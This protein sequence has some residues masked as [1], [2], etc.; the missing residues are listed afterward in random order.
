MA[1]LNEKNRY[2]MFKRANQ[3]K[4]KSYLNENQFKMQKMATA[5]FR[6]LVIKLSAQN[7]TVIRFEQWKTF[8][9]WR[10]TWILMY[11]NC[12]IT[13]I[14]INNKMRNKIRGIVL[15]SVVVQFQSECTLSTYFSSFRNCANRE[16]C[17]QHISSPTLI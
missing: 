8:W 4:L 5:W 14:D 11:N 3:F 10:S 1:H 16:S 7:N 13:W 12:C 2:L 6:C 9:H 17:H 15:I